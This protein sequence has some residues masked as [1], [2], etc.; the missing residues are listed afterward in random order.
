MVM[1]V[2][3]TACGSKRFRYTTGGQKGTFHHGAV[4]AY[5]LKPFTV[6]DLLPYTEI[7]PIARCLIRQ[8]TNRLAP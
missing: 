1:K 5:C 3:C 8:R 6:R 2:R 4:C 7:D